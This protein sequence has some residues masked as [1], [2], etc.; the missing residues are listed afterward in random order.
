MAEGQR[1]VIQAPRKGMHAPRKG[2]E[3][4]RKGIQAPRKGIEAPRKGGPA[5]RKEIKAPRKEI[6]APRKDMNAPRKEMPAPRKD[7]NAPRKEIKAPRKEMPAPRKGIRAPRKEM[8]TVEPESQSPPQIEESSSPSQRVEPQPQNVL[9]A[10]A[11]KFNFGPTYS[12]QERY[13][14]I[15]G[16]VAYSH[17]PRDPNA[18][19]FHDG[20]CDVRMRVAVRMV[21]TNLLNHSR[22]KDREY[23]R[24]F[25][26]E[27]S[28]LEKI[29]F[30][31]IANIY[32]IFNLKSDP[33]VSIVVQEWFNESLKERINRFT[34][35][36]M[37]IND[38]KT[39]HRQYF[40]LL[41]SGVDL[42]SVKIWM[43]QIVQAIEYLHMKRIVH[44]RIEPNSIMIRGRERAVLSHF[45]CAGNYNRLASQP[46]PFMDPRYYSATLVKQHIG[47]PDVQYDAKAN[48]VWAFGCTCAFALI[49]RDLFTFDGNFE[50]LFQQQFYCHQRIQNLPIDEENKTFLRSIIYN[51][52][53]NT[54]VE[55]VVKSPWYDN[56]YRHKTSPS[57]NPRSNCGDREKTFWFL[58]HPVGGIY[59]RMALKGYAITYLMGKGGYGAVYAGTKVDEE[60]KEIT[61]VAMKLLTGWNLKYET[62]KYR[63]DR[64]PIELRILTQLKHPNLVKVLDVFREQNTNN[65]PWDRRTFIWMERSGGDLWQ[66]AAEMPHYCIPEQSMARLMAYALKGLDFLHKNLIAHRDIKPGNILVFDMPHGEVA[67]IT[68]YSLIKEIQY[69]SITNSFT[70]TPGYQSPAVLMGYGYNPFKMDVFGIGMCIFELV[71]GRRPNWNPDAIYRTRDGRAEVRALKREVARKFPGNNLLGE[72]LDHFVF[73]LRDEDRYSAEEMLND[74]WFPNVSNDPIYQDPTAIRS[75]RQ[76]ETEN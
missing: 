30:K 63:E 45:L 16:Q 2:I 50:Q 44:N 35:N 47:H 1:P 4:P 21:H 31:F 29:E 7:M 17:W 6:R 51:G 62:G 68:D 48:D 64:Y 52:D 49:G 33:S 8:P 66:V 9:P 27:K 15:T 54:K 10:P 36:P 75:F 34:A 67:K 72:L 74:A 46:S 25:T 32:D 65:R 37:T 11:I 41:P 13:L 43:G 39:H 70:G 69:D 26:K 5:R 57:V 18:V 71:T 61:P 28:L 59:Y 58:G 22:A 60:T 19:T 23:L 38:V 53:Y 56:P 3:A 73:T 24:C 14:V 55:D 20:T 40:Q 12:L 76:F 42:V